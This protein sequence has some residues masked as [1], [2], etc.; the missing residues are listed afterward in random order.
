MPLPSQQLVPETVLGSLQPV[1]AM[2]GMVASLIGGQ[3]DPEFRAMA[4][5]YL[6]RASDR[7]NSAGIYL[8]ARKEQVYT[9]AGGD[10]SAGS[11][12]VT[13]PTDFAWPTFG[14]DRGRCLDSSGKALSV[15]EWLPWGRFRLEDEIDSSTKTGSPLWVS[16]LNE[17]DDRLY[18]TPGPDAEVATI[19]LPYF[20]RIQAPS[21]V[22]DAQLLLM[23]E[24]REALVTGGEFFMIRYRHADA[25]AIWVP[26]RNDFE[27]A[28]RRARG[29]AARQA[30]AFST[31]CVPDEIGQV[32]TPFSTQLNLL[33]RFS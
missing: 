10:Y 18:L 7:M 27:T 23:P 12:Y 20:A 6:D 19:R 28:I 21:E 3:D 17:F 2:I 8:H 24:V 30:G 14:A 1:D 25:P 32:L 11:R 16:Y 9:L 13:P 22:L 29:A 4:L 15:L 26:F 31:L 5:S 33:W